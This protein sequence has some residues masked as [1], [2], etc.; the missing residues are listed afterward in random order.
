[1][2]LRCLDDFLYVLYLVAVVVQSLSHIWLFE[3]PWTAAR[4]APLPF[5]ISQSLL[6]LMSIELVILS[7]HLILLELVGPIIQIELC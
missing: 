6:R 3:T 4:Q 5:T 1:M 7:N 2:F